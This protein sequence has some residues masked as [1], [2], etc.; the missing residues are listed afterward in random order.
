MQCCC[1]LFFLSYF[2]IKVYN[3][4]GSGTELWLIAIEIL[5]VTTLF[6]CVQLLRIDWMFN[7]ELRSRVRWVQLIRPYKAL[8][9]DKLAIYALRMAFIWSYSGMMVTQGHY[10]GCLPMKI[11][12]LL[13]FFVLSSQE[14]KCQM[15]LMNTWSEDKDDKIWQD[16]LTMAIRGAEWT[17]KLNT[18]IGHCKALGQFFDIAHNVTPKVPE[19]PLVVTKWLKVTLTNVPMMFLQSEPKLNTSNTICTSGVNFGTMWHGL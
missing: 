9:V 16:A 10:Q 14:I 7:Y 4:A 15:A 17:H 11:V 8:I 2:I 19:T 3:S 13:V 5:A 1:L 18:K 12:Q 6:C